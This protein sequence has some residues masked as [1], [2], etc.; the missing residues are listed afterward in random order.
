[1][2]RGDEFPTDNNQRFLHW[3]KRT[4]RV[5]H[6]WS[7]KISVLLCGLIVPYREPIYAFLGG[8]RPPIYQQLGSR[9]HFCNLYVGDFHTMLKFNTKRE[10]NLHTMWDRK[11]VQYL[12]SFNAVRKESCRRTKGIR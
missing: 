10:N 6:H 9:S 1:M 12:D 2:F 4:V 8:K 7:Y 5:G 11:V 3:F